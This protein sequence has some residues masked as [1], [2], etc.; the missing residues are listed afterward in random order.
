MFTHITLIDYVRYVTDAC[1]AITIAVALF[2]FPSRMPNI[3]CFRKKGGRLAV[4]ILPRRRPKHVH[5]EYLLPICV[6]T[7]TCRNLANLTE[8]WNGTERNLRA[9]PNIG[10]S[11]RT[12]SISDISEPGPVPA[13]LNWEIVHQKV[14]WGVIF[15]V[16]GGFALAK[17]CQVCI[18][19]RLNQPGEER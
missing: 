2:I 8:C 14:P 17:A 12:L 18:A 11:S 10:N 6:E 3:L 5:Y 7:V 19:C 9:R 15:V 16:G 4:I 1:V 13:L